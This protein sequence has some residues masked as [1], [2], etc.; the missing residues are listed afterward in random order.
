MSHVRSW[1]W[2][3]TAVMPSDRSWNWYVTVWMSQL[4]H[5]RSCHWY[6]TVIV[7]HDRSWHCYVTVVV[8]HDIMWR[9]YVEVVVSQDGRNTGMVQYWCYR[10]WQGYVTVTSQVVTLV[11]YI[12][13]VSWHVMTLVCYMTGLDTGVFQGGIIIFTS[14]EPII[15]AKYFARNSV[16]RELDISS[17]PAWLAR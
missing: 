5:D 6:F 7:S 16:I 3:V 9:W 17:K 12:I 2:Y 11:C 10:S 15:S 8:S 14:P 13:D 4:S 1:H